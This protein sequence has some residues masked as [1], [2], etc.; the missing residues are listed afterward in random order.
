MNELY[1]GK[2]DIN[3]IEEAIKEI[4]EIQIEFKKYP[5]DCVIWDIE[6][7]TKQPP[8][9]KN[10][11]NQITDLPNYFVTSD[12]DDLI[13]ILLYALEKGNELKLPVEIESI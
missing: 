2:L 12:G 9:G 10:I 4:Q 13:T 3:N 5:P 6:D 11:S 7:I 1:Q 8:W